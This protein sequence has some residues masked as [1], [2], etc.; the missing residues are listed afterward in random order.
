M[1]V[2]LTCTLLIALGALGLWS[3]VRSS[4][5]SLIL[6]SAITTVVQI[7]VSLI[8]L[9]LLKQL[10]QIAI[11][12]TNGA[13]SIFLILS[14]LRPLISVLRKGVAS[15]SQ[16]LRISA[17]KPVISVVVLGT[18]IT[19]MSL[20]LWLGLVL[21]PTDWDGLAQNLPMAAFHIQQGDIQPI[22]TPYRGITAYPQGGA[23][24]IA[25][26]ILLSGDD[27]IIDLV[28]FP[29]WLL[30]V[31]AVFSL[32][33]EL[34][35]SRSN[36]LIGALLFGAAPV[37]ILQSRSAYFDVELAALALAALALLLDRGLGVAPR[38][39]GAS[40]G[41]GLLMGLKY[42]GLIYACVLLALLVAFLVAQRASGRVLLL[43]ISAYGAVCLTIGGY[44]YA[45]NLL[46]YGNPF[47][48]MQ[49]Q[50]GSWTAL[51][52]VWTT[53]SFYGGALPAGVADLPY[54]MMLL[55]LWREPVGRYA[56][57]SRLGG[58]GPLWF[59]FGLPAL[60]FF[61]VQT[62][63]KPS[64]F[65]WSLLLFIFGTFLLTPANWHTRYV[66]AAVGAA[67]VCVAAMFE[68]AN[69]IV[70]QILV[71]LAAI[72]SC[73]VLLMT[74][75]HGEATPTDV[76]RNMQLPPALR[77]TTLMDHVPAMDKALRWSELNIPLQSTVVY[78]WGGVVL[79]PLF[80]T[81]FQNKLVAME[82]I[83]NGSALTTAFRPHYFIVRH[84]SAEERQAR[85]QAGLVAVFASEKYV[86]FF[87]VRP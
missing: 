48:P 71:G 74:P 54:P 6:G 44:W 34:G 67:G 26:A 84:G 69:G 8:A 9:G 29:F 58:L 36:S 2:L 33:R 79:Y 18:L 12:L 10:N 83:T 15:F 76:V 30:G 42:A 28:Q 62:I 59:V 32:A 4:A 77:R 75:A 46:R 57:D 61:L 20:V 66:L 5:R 21:P 17:K 24:L 39:L 82:S 53:D 50:I 72:L 49:L 60:I 56:V 35:A 37:V 63:R 25:Y 52:G 68:S 7:T 80:G 64:F 55:T 38:I 85:E 70:R 73:A 14:N 27:A 13:I 43:S 81:G 47:W 87:G 31:L 86:V 11:V 23:L 51:P 65:R 3:R 19:A 78:G 1:S 16:E 40:G 45:L 41:A 22:E